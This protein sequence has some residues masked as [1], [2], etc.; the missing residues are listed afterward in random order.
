M[1]HCFYCSKGVAIFLNP[2]TNFAVIDSV[3]HKDGRFVILILTATIHY[4]NLFTFMAV[5]WT[6]FHYFEGQKGYLDNHNWDAIIWEGDFNFVMNL[7]LD[8]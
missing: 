8:N 1:F 4:S 2:T 7:A 6:T 5:T 3:I